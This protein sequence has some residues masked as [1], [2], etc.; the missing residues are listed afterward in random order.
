[1]F[2]FKECN[3]H[4]KEYSIPF[5]FQVFDSNTDPVRTPILVVDKKLYSRSRCKVY[6]WNQ[7]FCSVSDV[8]SSY[9]LYSRFTEWI[10]GQ[11]THFSICFCP[12]EFAGNNELYG[13]MV[14]FINIY[15]QLGFLMVTS[16]ESLDNNLIPQ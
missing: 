13:R 3:K 4:L 1:M 12:L 14:G 2:V 7:L 8:M 11:E 15:K 6:Q 9:F 16:H 10:R 5:N